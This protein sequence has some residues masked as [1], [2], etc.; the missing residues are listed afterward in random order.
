MTLGPDP[1]TVLEPLSLGGPMPTDFPREWTKFLKKE[2]SRRR[3]SAVCF[4]LVGVARCALFCDPCERHTMSL[5]G[6]CGEPCS[7]EFVGS[8]SPS[9]S[10]RARKA[11]K[12]TVSNEESHLLA[13]VDSMR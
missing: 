3:I 1:S 8:S 13:L 5:R 11:A 2:M 10:L 7:S 4:C 9:L 6:G 12:A